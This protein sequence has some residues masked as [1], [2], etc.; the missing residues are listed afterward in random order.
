MTETFS[1][2]RYLAAKRP[3]DDAALNRQVY[4]RLVEETTAAGALAGLEIRCGTGTM[5]ERLGEWDFFGAHAGSTYTGVDGDPANIAVARMVTTPSHVAATWLTAEF[6]AF[7]ARCTGRFDLV[8]AN[9]VLDLLALDEALPALHTLLAPGGLAWL[10]INF[11]GMTV[12]EPPL[13]PA[14]DALI[15]RRYHATM[16]ERLPAGDSR[17]GRHLFVALPR[18]GLSILAAGA[19]DWAVFPKDGAYI[20]DEAYFLAHM[21]HFMQSSLAGDPALDPA[22]LRQ[23]IAAR[24]LQIE[25]ARLVLIAHQ[26]DFLARR[27]NQP[28]FQG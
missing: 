28:P 10:T 27:R 8:I 15:E 12:L 26:F 11:D 17:T 7:A 13:D 4:A 14:L 9:A 3:I 19:S 6:H 24:A 23:W 1:F 5:L 20:G 21:L 18:H 2:T 25:Q 22:L 16:D